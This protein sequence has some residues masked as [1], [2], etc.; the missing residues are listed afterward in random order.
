MTILLTFASKTLS[1]SKHYRS[2]VLSVVLYLFRGLL[3]SL[4]SILTSFRMEFNEVSDIAGDNVGGDLDDDEAISKSSAVRIGDMGGGGRSS[5]GGGGNVAKVALGGKG[6]GTGGN[7]MQLCLAKGAQM[8]AE[9]QKMGC[10]N[11]DQ[12]KG[13]QSA[14]GV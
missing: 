8:M 3:E 4:L 7:K 5:S 1:V 6:G 11:G 12:I 9:L 13:I 10:I 2:L 14:L